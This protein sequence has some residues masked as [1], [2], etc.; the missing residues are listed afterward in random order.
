MRS[1]VIIHSFKRR[2]FR[3]R[4][5]GFAK[6][7]GFLCGR[8]V[9]ALAGLSRRAQAIHPEAREVRCGVRGNL[10]GHSLGAQSLEEAEPELPERAGADGAKAR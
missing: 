10:R 3:A 6:R 1:I 7:G 5:T 9:L 2:R 4:R 8:Q